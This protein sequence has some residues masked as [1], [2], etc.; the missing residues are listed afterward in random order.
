MGARIA[1]PD[2]LVVN[3]M[4]DGA[5]GMTSMD[6][7]TAARENIPT[8]TV[9]KHDSVFS[10]YFRHIPVAVEK[11]HGATQYGDY[12]TLARALGLHAERVTK[13]GELR[14]AFE[15]A[16]QATRDGQPALVDVITSE[17]TKLSVP[18][19]SGTH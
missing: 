14:P 12:A 3:V 15:R 18:P 8:L 10:G 16:I 17:T 11:F 1:N 5:I 13:V 7:E 9:V 6:L 4:G 2:K 19:A